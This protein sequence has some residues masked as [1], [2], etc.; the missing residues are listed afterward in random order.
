MGAVACRA[1][2]KQEGMWGFIAFSYTRT[3]NLRAEL[4]TAP[5]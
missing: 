2:H 4:S 1:F 3:G 5:M